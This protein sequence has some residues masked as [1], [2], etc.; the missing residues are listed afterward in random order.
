M[1]L[2]DLARQIAELRIETAER[3]DALERAVAAAAAAR[4][5]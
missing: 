5:V 2:G 1:D 4:R 3:L